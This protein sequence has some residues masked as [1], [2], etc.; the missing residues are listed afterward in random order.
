MYQS[1]RDIIREGK[2]KNATEKQ[3]QQYL[4]LFHK[5]DTEFELKNQLLE[6]LSK[7]EAS[8]KDKYFFDEIFER[9]WHKRRIEI[10]SHYPKKQFLIRF[11]QWAAILIIGLFLGY[12]LNSY[13]KISTPVY[14]TSIAP[15]GSVSEMYLPDGSH[16]FLNSGSE[17]KYSVDGTNGIREIFL[18]GEA[19]FQVAKM[20]E[21]PFVVHTSFYT[22]QVTG[23]SFNVKAYPDENEVTTT[24]EEGMVHVK[25]SENM[26]LSKDIALKP[27]EQ[28][29][30]NKESKDINIHQ[31]NTKWYTSWKDNK[32]VF[33]N[34]SLK[35]LKILLERKYGVEIEIVDQS[36][37]K[38]HYDGTI[39]NESIMEVLE[40]LKHT[41]PIQYQII[42]QKIIIKKKL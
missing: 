10:Q 36:I 12:Y 5:T 13:Y 27:G 37:L 22:I 14:Y 17:I 2:S 16:I 31:V 15:N 42:D 21:K 26:K 4:S 18:S 35:D 24:L 6:E 33:I 41:L 29:I 23:T 3:R 38:Y 39:K 20:K 25:S 9:L 19:W 7:T 34:M 8:L 1:I 11:S 30:F 40:I 28:L 32:I